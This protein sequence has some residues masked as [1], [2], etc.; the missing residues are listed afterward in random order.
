MAQ[1][2]TIEELEALPAGTTIYCIN[3]FGC[4]GNIQH[5]V[6]IQEHTIICKADNEKL[7]VHSKLSDFEKSMQ[8][9]S[10]ATHREGYIYSSCVTR[11]PKTVY[12]DLREA[13]EE[14]KAVHNDK[15]TSIVSKHHISCKSGFNFY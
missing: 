14:L 8:Q 3:P 2:K 13:K 5:K 9:N 7:K 11:E 15:Y 10:V 1:V 4:G 6:Q 12:T